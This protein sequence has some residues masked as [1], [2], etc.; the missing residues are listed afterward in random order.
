MEIG[1]FDS[2]HLH[3][4]QKI[5]WLMILLSD[6]SSFLGWWFWCLVRALK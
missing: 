6:F 2:P 1:D 4:R 5:T 3:K